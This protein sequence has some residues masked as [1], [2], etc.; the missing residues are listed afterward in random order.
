MSRLTRDR[1]DSVTT[2]KSYKP[3]AKCALSRRHD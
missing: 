2:K 3:S 1:H